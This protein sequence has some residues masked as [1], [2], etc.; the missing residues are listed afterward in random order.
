MAVTAAPTVEEVRRRADELAIEFYFAQFVD[1]YARPSAKL[2][3]AASFDGLI[4]EGAGFAGFAAGEIGQLPH[5]PDLL[6]R[7][8][9][10]S[11]TPVPWQPGLARFAC[12]LFVEG[13]EWPYDP[14]AILRRQLERAQTKGYELKLGLELEYF[15]I[16]RGEHGGIAIADPLDT[17]A[18]PCYDLNGL[19]R[20]YEFLTT[21]SRYL[22]ELGWGNYANDHE[23]ANGQFEQNFEYADALTSCDRAIFFR[24]M[25]HTL[26]QRRGL[27]ATFM[28]KPFGHLTGNGC[29]FHMS[30]WEGE[31]NLFLDADDPRGLGLS[32]LAYNFLGGLKRHAVAYIAVTASTVNSYKRLKESTLTQSG[33]TW[34]PVYVSYGYNNRTQMLRVPGPGRIEDRTVDGSCNPYLAATVILAAGLDGIE[35]RL[36]PGEPN[37][38]NLHDVGQGELDRLGVEVLPGNLLDATRALERDD[39]LRAALG[40]AIGEDYLDYYVRVKRGEWAAYHEQVTPWELERYLT[41]T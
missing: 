25:I 19:T 24:Y 39:V 3:P 36:D 2:V 40:P 20:N 26:A 11:F 6:A 14:R 32:E 10:S 23:D 35:Q 7:P 29:H 1:M 34:S 4:A 28:P 27:L 38:L 30:L 5:H 21:V 37:T 16:S 31:T 12:D 17:L 15:L 33:A 8:D 18:K 22:N 9:L 13:E 41:L